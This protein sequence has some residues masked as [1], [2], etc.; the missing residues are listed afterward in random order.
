MKLSE[1]NISTILGA[2]VVLVVGILLFNYFKDS[3]P[4]DNISK[5]SKPKIEME[6]IHDG[7]FDIYYF[8]YN[9][10]VCLITNGSRKG[11]ISCMPKKSL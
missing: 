1:E 5:H 4:S 11:G 9:D 10:V 7:F 3:N 8:E 2:V 6:L